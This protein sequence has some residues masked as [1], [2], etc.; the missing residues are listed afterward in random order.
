MSKLIYLDTNIYLDYFE[1]RVDNLRP[2][3]EFAFQ[4]I[5]RAVSCEFIIILSP[6]VMRELENNYD[7]NKINN[8][9]SD[10]REIN[11]LIEV[12]INENDK[13]KARELSINKNIHYSDA[14]HVVLAI[15]SNAEVLITRNIIHFSGLNDLIKIS[16]PES[17]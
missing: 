10:L 8:F 13:Q 4:L 6:H 2:L 7:E 5:K 11:K 12:D 15:K 17:I 14:L 1:G 3:G 9:F 16:F